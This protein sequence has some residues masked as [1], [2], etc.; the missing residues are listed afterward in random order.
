MKRRL[1]SLLTA[2]VLAVSMVPMAAFADD[3]PAADVASEDENTLSVYAWDA[4]F[5]IP[6]LEAAAADYQ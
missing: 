5:N 4:N 2:G 1:I 3:A 6:A